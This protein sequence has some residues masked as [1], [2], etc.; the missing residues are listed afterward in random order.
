MDGGT[1]SGN[2]CSNGGVASVADGV[3]LYGT[4]TVFNM[5]AGTISSNYAHNG[6]NGVALG[7]DCSTFTMSGGHPA[8]AATHGRG[9]AAA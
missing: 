4:D 7:G 5:T 3:S 1:I 2:H 9:R 6:G 8:T